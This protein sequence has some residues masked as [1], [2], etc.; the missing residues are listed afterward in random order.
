MK[1]RA[2]STFQTGSFA[3]LEALLVPLLTTGAKNAAEAVL[4]ISLGMVPYDTGELASSG[5]T[6]V[7][8]T[9]TKVTGYV[10]YSSPHAA[11]NEFGTGRRGEES[12]HGA[13]GI[14]YKQSWPGM[15]GHP[16]IR[17]ALDIGRS[18]IV[19]AFEEA[20]GV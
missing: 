1:L 12:G 4:E 3:R 15:P 11:Y 17:P 13:P 18:Q 14:T 9:G 20:L 2:T 6:T 16:Y 7:E 5:H 10:I 19:T 8:W